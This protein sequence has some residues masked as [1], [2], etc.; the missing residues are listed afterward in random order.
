M[1]RILLGNV[2]NPAALPG[3]IVGAVQSD[4]NGAK[5]R[6]GKEPEKFT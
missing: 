4:R 2:C 1:A 6:P 5:P 3:A